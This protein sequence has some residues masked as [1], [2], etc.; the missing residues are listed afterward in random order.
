M[1]DGGQPCSL[2]RNGFCPPAPSPRKVFARLSLL[3]CL[4]L[5]G[6][7]S[8]ATVVGPKNPVRAP[9]VPGLLYR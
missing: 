3:T 9:S 6:V 1:F 4:G 2:A 5:Y 7:A 8:V